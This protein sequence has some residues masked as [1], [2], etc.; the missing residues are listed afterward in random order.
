MIVTEYNGHT[1]GFLVEAVD[2]ILRLDWASMKVP[3]DM[4]NAQLGGLVVAVTELQDK[5]LVMMMDVEKVLA[6]TGNFDTNEILLKHIKPIG[7]ATERYFSLMI[8][9]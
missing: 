2:T 4:L 3:P 6:D 1:Q 5:R 8:H 9:R 7:L